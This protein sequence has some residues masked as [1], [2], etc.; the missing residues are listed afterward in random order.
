MTLTLLRAATGGGAG[1]AS[2][3]TSVAGSSEAGSQAG[4]GGVVR[5][6]REPTVAE[7][8]REGVEIAAAMLA[9]LDRYRAMGAA[10]PPPMATPVK[11]PRTGAAARP[12]PAPAPV[13]A[14]GGMSTPAVVRSLADM[15]PA[16]PLPERES[17]AEAGQVLP[18]PPSTH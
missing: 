8:G 10:M 7:R 18:P 1:G 15:S 16:E 6:A 17:L 3:G 9:Q 2:P 5:G 13:P 11:T 4:G 12:P 14:A